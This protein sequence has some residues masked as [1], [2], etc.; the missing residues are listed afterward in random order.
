MAVKAISPVDFRFGSVR[1]GDGVEIGYRCIGQG[2]ALILLHGAMM[3]SA[4]FDELAIAMADEFTVYV[5]D[6]RGHGMSRAGVTVDAAGTVAEC[7]LDT[8][9]ADLAALVRETG[10]TRVFGLSSGGLIALA[11]ALRVP[12]IRQLAIYEPALA[13]ES[14]PLLTMMARIE[15]YLDTNRPAAAMATLFSATADR[16]SWMSLPPMVLR[17]LMALLL[18]VDRGDADQPGL[19]ESL[20]TFRIDIGLA[21]E[22]ATLWDRWP[23]LTCDTLLLGG[24]RS[25]HFLSGALD[26]LHTLLPNAAR[27]TL[28]GTGHSAAFNGE[29]PDLVATELRRFLH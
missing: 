24:E 28:P 23:E 8:E 4:L 18:H 21:R 13:V 6:R 26:H 11:A 12:Q 9:I 19:R 5:P 16:G 17:P 10:A 2:P 14:G 3:T 25:P 22:G 27:A 15:R 7:G 29:K 20:P 1:A